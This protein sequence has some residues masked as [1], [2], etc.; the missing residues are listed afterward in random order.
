MA[1]IIRS[2]KITFQNASTSFFNIPVL[3]TPAV[4]EEVLTT[5][6][7][8]DT[9][10]EESYNLIT[11]LD[12]AM[13]PTELEESAVIDFTVALFHATGYTHRPRVLRTRKEIRLLVCGE[14]RY[15]SP[16]VC[17]T[18]RNVGD[19]ILLMQEG[20]GIAHQS[21]P[22]ARLLVD[23]IAAFQYNN[24]RRISSGLDPLDSKVIPGIIMVGTSPIF[25]KIPITAELVQCVQRGEYPATPTVVVGHIPD[26]PRRNRRW[27]EG[28]KPLD[29]RRIMLQSFEA[30]KQFIA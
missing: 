22:H 5:E 19:I 2:A 27:S 14:Y 11:Q 8:D 12:L 15:A 9:V 3:P 18:D 26:I 13:V 4:N 6:S 23:A 1:N 16:D 7:A 29:N 21:D 17:I 25:F 28:M 24:T 20:K 10:D 30:F